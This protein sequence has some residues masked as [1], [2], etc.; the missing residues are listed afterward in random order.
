MKNN[1]M[2]DLTPSLAK[3]SR[4]LLK[5]GFRVF[6]ADEDWSE[7]YLFFSFNNRMGYVE[8]QHTSIGGVLLWSTVN[9]LTKRIAVMK[10]DVWIKQKSDS[11]IISIADVAKST[12]EA[13]SE[14]EFSTSISLGE[15]NSSLITTLNLIEIKET[16]RDQ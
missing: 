11:L 1:K 14:Y 13:S 16:V 15:E 5:S 8:E 12:C 4:E 2:S 9:G 6:R 7:Q 3:V 10:I